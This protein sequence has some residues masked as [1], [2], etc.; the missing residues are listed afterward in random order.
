MRGIQ[1]SNSASSRQRT[2][3]PHI[4]RRLRGA[5]PPE[6]IF[7]ISYIFQRGAAV[8]PPPPQTKRVPPAGAP[9]WGTLS[10]SDACTRPS[11]QIRS[12]PDRVG[13]GQV[14]PS[15]SGNGLAETMLAFGGLDIVVRAEGSR[16]VLDPELKSVLVGETGED[17]VA[18]RAAAAWLVHCLVEEGQGR[19]QVADGEEGMLLIGASLP[20]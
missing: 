5:A 13:S 4:G 17:E 14:M 2:R 15:R 10:S 1:R 11:S 12:M 6:P 7:F 3:S 9:T 19:I 18:P 16:I 8:P 20:A